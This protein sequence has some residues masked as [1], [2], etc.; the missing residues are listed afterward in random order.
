MR[1]DRSVKPRFV[2]ELR[3]VRAEGST[4]N[5]YWCVLDTSERG[6]QVLRVSVLGSGRRFVPN[7]E[8]LARR[9]AQQLNAAWVKEL[10]EKQK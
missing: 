4:C 1:T 3:E 6:F 5:R 2:A 8:T 10:R 7:A 9:Y